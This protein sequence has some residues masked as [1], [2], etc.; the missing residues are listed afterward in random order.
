[1]KRKSDKSLRTLSEVKLLNSWCFFSLDF[2]PPKL[3]LHQ[4]SS[5][6]RQ[7]KSFFTYDCGISEANEIGR[8][9]LQIKVDAMLE[10]KNGHLQRGN[11]RRTGMAFR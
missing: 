9:I 3:H 1:M 4:L 8:T 11:V 5:A 10:G 6:F 2:K 7:M